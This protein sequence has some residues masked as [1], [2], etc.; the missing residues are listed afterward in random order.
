M[1]ETLKKV[2]T[3]KALKS[4]IWV[5]L[6]RSFSVWARAFPCLARRPPT[7]SLRQGATHDSMAHVIRALE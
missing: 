7:T 3:T 4:C 5:N 1:I 2:P 6:A